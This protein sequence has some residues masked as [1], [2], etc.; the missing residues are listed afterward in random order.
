MEDS[1]ETLLNAFG[2]RVYRFYID[3]GAAYIHGQVAVIMVANDALPHAVVWRIC[4]DLLGF[5]DYMASGPN[6]PGGPQ[7]GRPRV[8]EGQRQT[9]R[10]A[11]ISFGFRW[12]W[13]RRVMELQSIASN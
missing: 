5:G 7:I 10:M 12:Q 2:L 3:T 13:R 1:F 8:K 4:T 6:Y 11:L 9:N